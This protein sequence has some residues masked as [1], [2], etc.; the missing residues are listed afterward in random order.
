[1]VKRGDV[2]VVLVDAH[3]VATEAANRPNARSSIAIVSA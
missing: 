3:A 2:L 1:M